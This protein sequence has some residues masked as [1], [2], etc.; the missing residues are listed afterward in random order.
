MPLWRL[1]WCL[2]DCVTLELSFIKTS[3]TERLSIN[4]YAQKSRLERQTSLEK[5]TTL[6][7]TEALNHKFD[8]RTE[9]GEFKRH[10]VARVGGMPIFQVASQHGRRN[11]GGLVTG[12]LKALSSARNG[13]G[14]NSSND[15]SSSHPTFTQQTKQKPTLA[16]RVNVMRYF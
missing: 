1:V 6:F 15:P 8:T 14:R 12:C 4:G 16:K 9:G 10:Q 13:R 3:G 5:T 7:G 11:G 2:T